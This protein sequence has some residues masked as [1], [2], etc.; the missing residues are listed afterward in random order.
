MISSGRTLSFI[1]VYLL[2]QPFMPAWTHVTSQFY[3]NPVG[4]Y[5]VM[6]QII[7]YWPL[8]DCLV[9]LVPVLKDITHTCVFMYKHTEVCLCASEHVYINDHMCPGGGCVC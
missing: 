2:I 1:P 7:G 6:G 8:V 4:C 3:Y 5:L 9:F